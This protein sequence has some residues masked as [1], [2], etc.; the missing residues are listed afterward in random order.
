[1]VKVY[2]EHS[3][4]Y[5]T[6][7]AAVFLLV[8]FAGAGVAALLFAPKS[9]EPVF[10]KAVSVIEEPLLPEEKVYAEELSARA[11]NISWLEN[12]ASFNAISFDS[13]DKS[14]LADKGLQLYRNPSTRPAV[15]WF[16]LRVTGNRDVTMA[17]LDAA[18]REDIPLSLAFA[19]CHTESRYNRYAY[20]LNSN[21]SIDRGLFQLNDRSFPHLAENDF[22]T[23]ETSARV[24]MKHLRFCLNVAGNDLTAVA[25][26]N[27]GVTRVRNDQTPAST[28][29]YV[30]R[31]ASYRANLQTAFAEEVLDHY[32]ENG[33][34]IVPVISR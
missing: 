5:K 4:F 29:R 15:E 8:L 3:E 6:A 34:Q 14:E 26:Y 9:E 20:N 13:D 22:Y 11:Q 30:S 24:G 18:N 32:R 10:A 28:L 33:E 1:M 27:A 25:M 19:L 23:A 7:M 17:V 2:K 21:G 31:I 12:K 16:Y